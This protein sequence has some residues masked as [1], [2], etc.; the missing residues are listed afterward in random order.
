MEVVV[1]FTFY[2]IGICKLVHRRPWPVTV[3][4]WDRNL[5]TFLVSSACF[6]VNCS[7]LLA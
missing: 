2:R 6:L 4:S 1:L 7:D 3:R 5:T